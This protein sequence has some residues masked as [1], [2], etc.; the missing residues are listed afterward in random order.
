MKAIKDCAL[1]MQSRALPAGFPLLVAIL[2]FSSVELQPVLAQGSIQ[3]ENGTLVDFVTSFS[4][5]IIPDDSEMYVPPS[6]TDLNRMRQLASLIM[7]SAGTNDAANLSESSLEASRLGY[8]LTKLTNEKTGIAYYIL[9]ETTGKNRGW[10]LYIF[11][12][13]GGSRDLVI[14]APHPVD[15]LRTDRIGIMAF[16]E[17]KARAFLVAGTHRKANRDGSSD[18][19]HSP[20]SI[21]EAVH[22][23][24]TKSSTTVIQVHGFTLAKEPGYPQVVL[25]SGDEVA[26]SPVSELSSILK[27]KGLTTEI[28]GG[29]ALKELEAA[30]N[31][32]GKYANSIGATFI[33]IELESSVRED[34]SKY[35]KVVSAISEFA[36]RYIKKFDAEEFSDQLK[37]G[38]WYYMAAALV[39]AVVLIMLLKP[40]AR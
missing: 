32:Q 40:H 6:D 34:P 18:A 4:A 24:V 12:A 16:S 10:G 13:G 11:R 7:I 37:P 31:A 17:S 15:D 2:F 3:E 27:A 20:H 23:A 21:F 35:R 36:S 1:I 22:E 5:R 14:E 33:H 38:L 8:D 9:R 26:A 30:T 39:I 25:S 28:S 29:G 19:A